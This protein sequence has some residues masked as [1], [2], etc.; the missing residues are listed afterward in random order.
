L[1]KLCERLPT[2]GYGVSQN[3]GGEGRFLDQISP[4]NQSRS[5]YG[6]GLNC[7]SRWQS[8]SILARD[9]K[10]RP[11]GRPRK[12]A[13]LQAPISGYQTYDEPLSGPPSP[14]DSCPLR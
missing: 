6:G 1:G 7:L 8:I 5:S 10:L 11:T 9:G 12:P 4:G 2:Q 14:P 3:H 13:M